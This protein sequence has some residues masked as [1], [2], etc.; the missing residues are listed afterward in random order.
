MCSL[1]FDRCGCVHHG[2][3]FV[4]LKKKKLKKGI[5]S[6]IVLKPPVTV[7]HFCDH[8]FSDVRQ[9]KSSAM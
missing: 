1:N 9:S 5:S 7:G 6:A 2:T 8:W 3:F 4:K